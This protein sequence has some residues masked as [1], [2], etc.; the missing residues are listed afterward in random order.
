M[1]ELFKGT[2]F[3]TDISDWD[4]SSVNTM[5]GMFESTPFNQ[6]ISGWDTSSVTSMNRMFLSAPFNQPHRR[7]ERVACDD[8][9]GHV[10]FVAVQSRHR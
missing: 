1:R 6:D 10:S 8:H 5:E 9:V 3:N 2:Q 7:L 4:T